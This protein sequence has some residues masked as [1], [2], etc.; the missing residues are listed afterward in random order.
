MET[1]SDDISA[2]TTNTAETFQT[3]PH[4]VI[5]KGTPVVEGPRDAAWH[6]KILLILGY[7]ADNGNNFHSQI[8]YQM[9]GT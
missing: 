7:M 4:S 9:W 6:L 3:R 5:T 1:A 8:V 2:I